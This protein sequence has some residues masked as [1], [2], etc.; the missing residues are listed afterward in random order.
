ME[1]DT[2]TGEKGRIEKGIT[3]SRA[4]ERKP[5]RDKAG[6]MNKLITLSGFADSDGFEEEYEEVYDRIDEWYPNAG[7]RWEENDDKCLR[8]LFLNG[9]SVEM[10]SVQFGRT[11]GAIRSRLRK[12]GVGNG[13]FPEIRSK[14]NVRLKIFSAGSGYCELGPEMLRTIIAR[15]EEFGLKEVNL[16]VLTRIAEDSVLLAILYDSN[17]DLVVFKGDVRLIDYQENGHEWIPKRDNR[18]P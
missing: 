18:A 15:L 2:Q 11:Y 12:V 3:L 6:Q 7:T 1:K 16:Y 13:G 9:L 14:T 5:T 17:C 8:E 10:I 4:N